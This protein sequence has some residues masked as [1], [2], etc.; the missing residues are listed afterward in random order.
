MVNKVSEMSDRKQS[1]S[2]MCASSGIG[3]GS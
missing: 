3:M 1:R 2:N